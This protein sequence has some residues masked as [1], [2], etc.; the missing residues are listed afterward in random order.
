MCKKVDSAMVQWRDN[1]GAI[2]HRFIAIMIVLSCHR[3]RVNALSP[4][5]C[6]TIASS[7]SHHRH[8]TIASSLYRPNL[9]GTILNYVALSGFH[10]YARNIIVLK[11]F[12]TDHF[13]ILSWGSSVYPVTSCRRR[14]HV[15]RWIASLLIKPLELCSIHGK[16]KINKKNISLGTGAK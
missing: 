15:D 2:E 5:H 14:L 8:R 6:R 7:K 13:T 4:S 11:W 12:N 3:L 16:W 9:D 10:R 1:D